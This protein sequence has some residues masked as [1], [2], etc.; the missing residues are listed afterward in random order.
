MLMQHRTF[1]AEVPKT[2]RFSNA[3]LSSGA[4]V[5]RLVTSFVSQKTRKSTSTLTSLPLTGLDV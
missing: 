3:L 4:N 5:P 1:G 2:T